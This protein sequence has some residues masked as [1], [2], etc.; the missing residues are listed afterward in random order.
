MSSGGD[1]RRLLGAAGLTALLLAGCAGSRPSKPAPPL[2]TV[3]AAMSAQPR[4]IETLLGAAGFG[5]VVIDARAGYLAAFS[6]AGTLLVMYKGGFQYV[7]QGGCFRREQ[8]GPVRTQ[9]AWEGE[10]SELTSDRYKAHASG[11]QA[12]YE[13]SHTESVTVDT[14]TKLIRTV[15]Q[16]AVPNEGLRRQTSTYSYPASV[17][18]LPAPRACPR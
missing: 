1:P 11:D 4:I 18:E 8:T 17:D 16:Q 15:S 9:I 5:R 14:R 3:S 12:V 7:L 10:L 13:S 6:P 2:S